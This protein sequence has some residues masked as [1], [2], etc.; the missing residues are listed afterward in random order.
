MNGIAEM[1]FLDINEENKI[2]SLNLKTKH[3]CIMITIHKSMQFSEK[4]IAIAIYLDRIK[5]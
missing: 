4:Y 3:E 2:I 1:I 5:P